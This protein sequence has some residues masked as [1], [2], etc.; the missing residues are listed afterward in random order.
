MTP[1]HHNIVIIGGGSAGITVASRLRRAS[2]QLSIALVE[3][4]SKHYY[5]PLWTLV[6][7]GVVEKSITERDEADLMPRG[8]NWI[9]AA[10]T[11]FEPAEKAVL[12]S[13]GER[14]TYDQLV[15]CPGIKLNWDDVPGLRSAMGGN[16]V[17]SN[18]SF[19]TV[20]STWE[21]LRGFQG[22]TAVF[23]M[24]QTAVKCGGAPQ[25]ILYLAEDYIRRRG[26]RD[27]S[28]FLYVA[29]G[30][31]IFGVD[32]YRPVLAEIVANRGIETLF[33]HHLVEVRGEARE[34]IVEDV[35]TKERHGIPFNLLHV[36]PPMSAPDFIKS[37]PL[38]DKAGW[39]DVDQ[40]T[41]QHKRFSDI[42]ALGDASNLP[43]GKTGAAIRKQA[44]VLVENLFA[45]RDGRPLTARYDGYTSCP[46]VTRRGRMVLAEFDYDGNPC[47]TFPF[48][49]AKE[50]FS[51]WILKRYIL[52]Q[53][54]WHGML[55]G[56]A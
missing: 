14:L 37:S 31:T 11:T 41:L 33:H 34:A 12:T 4:S 18:Y 45:H 10:A 7:A 13:D 30:P 54:Y 43:T 56:L 50:R 35:R 44:P 20:D 38:A 47:E 21:A 8:V 55:K 39:V 51:M 36:T 29:P 46:L 23:T 28:R 2:K 53:L 49:Q 16:G 1:T 22:G 5:Q 19:E 27:K 48:N 9:R 42:F 52:P 24:P 6:G 32:K 26:L 17:C 15:V 40:F 3:P 25:K